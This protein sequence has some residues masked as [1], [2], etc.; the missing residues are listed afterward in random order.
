MFQILLIMSHPPLVSSLVDVLVN[1]DEVA[2]GGTPE[3]SPL[4]LRKVSGIY[5]CINNLFSWYI[6]FFFFCT[7]TLS[8]D[9]Y[10]LE[11]VNIY[12]ALLTVMSSR[13]RLTLIL[14]NLSEYR[15]ILAELAKIR[16]YSLRLSRIIV[17]LLFNILSTKRILLL[18]RF[19]VMQVMQCISDES[20]KLNNY[21][22][23]KLSAMY[24]SWI[25]LLFWS[26]FCIMRISWL[27]N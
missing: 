16:W 4:P 27:K 18:E 13:M 3:D 20:W 7:V 24:K 26:Y 19:V 10:Y 1:G 22:Y 12:F 9:Y 14:S 15:L 23:R 2:S 6:F 5:F 25:T 8:D 11:K 17:K 21:V